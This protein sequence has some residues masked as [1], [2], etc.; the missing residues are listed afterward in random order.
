M[1]QGD[2][3]L[4]GWPTMRGGGGGGGGGGGQVEISAVA[5]LQ[6]AYFLVNGVNQVCP[7]R[8]HPHT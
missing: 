3:V 6:D 8:R 1:A 5:H 7:L 2:T 4:R